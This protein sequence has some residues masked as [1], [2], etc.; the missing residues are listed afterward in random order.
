[1]S[2]RKFT[3]LGDKKY[4]DGCDDPR[5]PTLPGLIRHGV[6]VDAIYEFMIIQRMSKTT[7]R[8]Q[9]NKLWSIHN[10]IIDNLSPRFS[11]VNDKL[12]VKCTLFGKDSTKQEYYRW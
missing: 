6:H 5:L 4:V 8:M 10:K 11:A 1:M 9:W 2:K 3:L 12:K 7:N